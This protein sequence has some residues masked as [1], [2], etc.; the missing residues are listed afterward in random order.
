MLERCVAALCNNVNDPENNISLHHR[1]LNLRHR[2]Q[3][4]GHF[5]HVVLVISSR[6]RP[7]ENRILN[8]VKIREKIA[9]YPNRKI[10]SRRLIGWSV[11]LDE[12][13][14][15]FDI[16]GTLSGYLDCIRRWKGFTYLKELDWNFKVCLPGKTEIPFAFCSVTFSLSRKRRKSLSHRVKCPFCCSNK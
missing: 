2:H 14:K 1:F 16:M 4:H 5:E 6:G 9:F 10:F 13:K 3:S 12:W 15:S 11:E 8:F 7:Q